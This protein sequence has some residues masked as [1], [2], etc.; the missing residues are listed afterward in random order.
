MRIVKYA[1]RFKRDYRREKSGPLGKRLDGLLME[2]VNLLAADTA[3][4]RRYFD[5]SLAGESRDHRDCHIRP[6]LVLI[7]RKHDPQQ[8]LDPH[9][10]SAGEAKKASQDRCS[11]L[12]AP[13]VVSTCCRIAFWLR[14]LGASYNALARK[15]LLL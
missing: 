10:G 1:G 2:A 11:L 5:H 12:C 3:L 8:G 7:Y 15:P 4:P 6:D 9:S 14:D 13:A